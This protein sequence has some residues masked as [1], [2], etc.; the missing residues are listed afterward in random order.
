[1]DKIEKII[2]SRTDNLG[3]VILT[4][5]IA[6]ILKKKFPTSKVIFIG[7]AYTKAIIESCNNIDLFLDREEIIADPSKLREQNADAMVLIYP[8]KEIAKAAFNAKIKIR[9]G[10]SHRWYNWIYCNKK[11]NFSRKK[12]DLHEAQLNC[13]LLK[14]L[15]IDSIPPL[16]DFPAYYG[17]QPKDELNVSIKNLI[18]PHK[19]NIIFHP[20]SKG[21]A[22]EWP[23]ENYYFLATEL[24]K[25]NF[26][27]FI[28]GTEGEGLLIKRQKP[29][30]F[31]LAN[32]IDLTGKLSLSEL[33]SFIN[34]SNGLL[35]CSTG[36]L[37]IGAALGKNVLGIYP[38]M[39]PIHPGRWAP[40]GINAAFV[41]YNKECLKCVKSGPCECIQ[42]ISVNQVK[43]IIQ[44][45]KTSTNDHSIK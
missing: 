41:V 40:I 5:P 14:P 2:I 34:S 17:F 1:M 29:E 4:L 45:W 8:D 38:P 28:T 30:I 31:E 15:G 7:K 19:F 36:P 21:S 27:V 44:K 25:E 11:V 26:K 24:S 12:S 10:T 13:K 35:A 42:S 16:S 37:H 18:D 43:N 39:R 32:I 33:I 9:I 20:K 3:D 22:R 23:I 6:G